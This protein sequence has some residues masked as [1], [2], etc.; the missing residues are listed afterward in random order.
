MPDFAIPVAV[1][2]GILILLIVLFKMMWRVAEPNEAL[3]ISGSIR[4]KKAEGTDGTLGFRTVSGSGTFVVPGIQTV[5]SLSLDLK[6][7]DLKVDCVTQQGIPVDVSGVVIFKIGDDVGSISNAARRFLGQEETMEDRVHNVFAGHLRSIVGGM[8][9]EDMIRD[10]TALTQQTRDA[11]GV[12]AEKLGLIIDS[13]QIQQIGD[14]TGYI[15]NLAKP[16]IAEVQK[17]ARIAEALNNR[18]AAEREA[19]AAALIAEAQRDSNVK[20]AEFA[21]TT[22][23]AQATAAQAGPLAEAEATKAVVQEQTE[24]ANLQAAKRE[25]EL[26]AEVRKPADAEA[27]AVEMQAQGANKATILDAEAKAKQTELVGKADGEAI[28]ARGLAEAE[29]IEARAKAL[30]T[31]PEAVVYQQLAENWPAI[32]EAAA[33]PFESIDNLTVL[34]GAGGVGE[35]IATVIASGAAGF[36]NLSALFQNQSSKTPTPTVMK[37]SETDQPAEGAVAS[38]EPVVEPAADGA[39]ASE[40]PSAD[41]QESGGQDDDK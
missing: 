34:N 36:Q 11:S 5:R 12:E 27:Y 40:Q 29:A 3:V 32:V 2:L 33:K 31:N 4:G 22:E 8:T 39:S 20:Q 30:A 41:E 21:A 14:P 37:K 26:D 19:E 18:E 16:H 10:R 15:E 1:G 7:A 28:K 24:V 13:L 17:N 9:I 25:R 6:K 23:Q 38:D 35:S